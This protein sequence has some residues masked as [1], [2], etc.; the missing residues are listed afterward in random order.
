MDSVGEGEI[1]DEQ[2]LLDEK[3]YIE[4]ENENNLIFN[5]IKD[6]IKNN[7]EIRKVFKIIIININFFYFF[8]E[9]IQLMY[10]FSR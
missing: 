8:K 4:N 3:S 5:N 6:E 2:N 9:F 10:P 1:D 7:Q